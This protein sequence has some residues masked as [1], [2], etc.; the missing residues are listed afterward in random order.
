[1]HASLGLWAL[2]KRR[3]FRWKATEII[4]LTLGLSVPVMLCTDLVGEHLGVSLYGLQRSYAQALYNFWERPDLGAMQALLVLVAWIYG[5]IGLYFWLRLKRF[6]SRLA[7]VLLALSVLTPTL[8]S[9][10]FYQQGRRSRLWHGSL[11]GARRS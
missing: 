1:M 8:A 7:P 11:S 9:L 4:Q 3:Y 10:G 6:F 5:C 2:Y